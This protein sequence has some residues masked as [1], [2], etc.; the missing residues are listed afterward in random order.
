MSIGTRWFKALTLALVVAF[1]LVGSATA[2]SPGE[3]D[4]GSGE[5]EKVVFT[6][7]DDNDIDSM[8][9][10]VGVEAPAYLMYSLNYDLLVNFD[11]KDLS[12]APGLAESWENSE[13]GLT[14]TFKIREGMK[15]SDGE[16][17][18][19]HDI[20]YTWNRVLEE[21][22]GAY[23]SYLNLVETAEAPDDTT[24]VVTTKKPTT[25]VLSAYVYTMPEHIWKDISKEERKTFENYPNPVTSGAFHVVEWEKG[26]FFRM[27][28]NEDYWAGAPKIDE[29]VYRVF[30]NEDALVQALKAGEIDFADTLGAGLYD[31][32]EGEADISRNSATIPS[33]EEIGFNVGARDVY[34]DSDGHPALE[35]PIVR[36]AIAHAI[37]K[38]TLVDRVQLGHAT[39]G[40]TIVPPA[41]DFYHYEPAE[42]ETFGFDP[43]LANQML[44]DAGYLDTDGDGVREMPGGGEPLFFRHYV[45]SEKNSTVKSAE[46][47]K[48]WLAAIGIEVNVK[49]LTDTKLTDVIYA[50][51]YDMFHWG[52]YPDPD[53]DFILSVL[54]CAQRPPEGIW[55]DSYYCNDE[56]EQMYEDQKA[57]LDLDER[58]AVIDEMQRM[59][60]EEAPYVVLYYDTNLQ[61]YRSDRWTGFVQQPTEGG[62]LLAGYGPVSY[63]SIHPVSAESAQE[64]AR[65]S[66]KG[67]PV[68]VWIGLLALIVVGVVVFMRGRGSTGRDDRA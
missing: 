63:I 16:P 34:P 1:A 23:I 49:P 32:L 36:Q 12:P 65:D 14:W 35:D 60:Y 59:V 25:S 44:D 33:F 47:I 52:W 66:S 4:D 24:F 31:S 67:F 5:D 8:N 7:G 20:A 46:F 61:A 54:T 62:D 15:W 28:A 30:N 27:E 17:L 64:A 57:I 22:I 42:D 56:Y 9:P 3:S 29:V 19:A 43:D 38:Q 41:I 55:S 13:D 2:Q 10:F 45:R 58:A 51:D 26:Q 11:V 40:S 6:V 53:P 21:R 37:D 68:T 18:T 50:G 48:E 39:V